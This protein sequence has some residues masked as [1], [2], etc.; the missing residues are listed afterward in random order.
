MP[1]RR[2]GRARAAGALF[3]SLT[4]LIGATTAADDA[5]RIADD[6]EVV[7]VKGNVWRHVSSYPINER[8]AW[9]NGLIVVTDEGIA[10][11]DTPWTVEQ[12][13]KLLKWIE[14][15]FDAPIRFWVVTHSHR[16]C[17]GGI[18]V[19]QKRGIPTYASERTVRFAREAGNPLPDHAFETRERLELGDETIEAGFFGAGH[20]TDNVVVWVAGERVL[21]GGCMIRS[22]GSKRLGY[23]AEGDLEAWPQTLRRIRK[24]YPGP[25]WV[26]PGHGDP[27]GPALIDNTLRLLEER[28]E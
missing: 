8:P 6:L 23:T 27:G 24:V 4:A 9:A 11:V 14:K 25:K 2:T 26:V 21:F 13:E 5:I 1:V 15:K 17:M 12:T 20:T 22:A 19:L 28:E 7:A 18:G 10:G 16:D 3:V